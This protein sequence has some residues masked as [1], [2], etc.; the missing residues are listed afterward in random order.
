MTNATLTTSEGLKIARLMMVISSLSPL[1]VL[2][3]IRGNSYIPDSI[4]YIICGVFVLVPLCILQLRIMVAKKGR[5]TREVVAGSS[6]D[7]RNQVLV[8]LFSILLPF[9][10]QDFRS[11][12]EFAA[13]AAALTFII[14]LFWHLNY[15]YMNIVF[16][17]R[18]YRIYTVSPP[19]D[20]NRFSGREQFV[21]ISKRRYLIEGDRIHAIR[22]SN[23]VY[24]ET[25]E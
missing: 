23:T 19:A 3:A 4:L 12:R 15:H 10:R 14:F 8:Y 24:M 1:F 18:G 5:D 13:M 7:H 9:Y 20:G 16:A 21:L 22:L 11:L 25:S 6:E 2:W 17:L